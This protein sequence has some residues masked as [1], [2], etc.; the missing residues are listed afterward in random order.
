MSHDTSGPIPPFPAH[1]T[2]PKI[3]TTLTT[4]GELTPPPSLSFYYAGISAIWIWYAAPLEILRAY[5]HPLHMTPY[6]FG[7]YGAV[8]INFFNALALYGMGQPGSKGV[9]GFNETEINIIG[10][11]T[12]V[13]DHVPQGMT[14]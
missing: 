11:A 5:L 2:L 8:N 4:V 7:G 10:S 14:L 3:E 12:K 9:G 1:I 13:A 6:D